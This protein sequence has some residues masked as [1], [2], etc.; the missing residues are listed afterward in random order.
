MCVCDNNETIK[1]AGL[2]IVSFSLE[3]STRESQPDW[4]L[5]VMIYKIDLVRS[6]IEQT[7]LASYRFVLL[8]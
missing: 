8:L 7:I 4:D 5:I 1:F 2:S 6:L 3:I